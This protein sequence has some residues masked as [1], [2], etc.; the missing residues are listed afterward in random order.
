VVHY[1]RTERAETVSTWFGTLKSARQAVERGVER[2]LPSVNLAAHDRGEHD[3]RDSLY[4]CRACD[5][6]RWASR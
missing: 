2:W 1:P 6:R 5:E 4:G 3:E